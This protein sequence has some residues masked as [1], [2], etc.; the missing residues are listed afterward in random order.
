MFEKYQ[1]QLCLE[2]IKVTVIKIDSYQSHI[3]KLE[4]YC[5]IIEIKIYIAL[6]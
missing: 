4:M 2:Y 3:S 6:K 1:H 5:N